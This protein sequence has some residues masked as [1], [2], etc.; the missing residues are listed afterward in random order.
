VGVRRTVLEVDMSR[1]V[2]GK[3]FRR[4]MERWVRSFGL[5]GGKI[6]PLIACRSFFRLRYQIAIGIGGILEYLSVASRSLLSLGPILY[7]R[8]E[9]IKRDMK[10]LGN[11]VN[12]D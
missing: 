4:I 8:Q 5:G 10:G 7:T 2:D 3:G 11:E 6:V 9:V 1:L 12:G